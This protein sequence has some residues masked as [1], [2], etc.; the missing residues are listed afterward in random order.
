MVDVMVGG[1]YYNSTN[2]C[3]TFGVCASDGNCGF[4]T[5]VVGGR[6]GS[7]AC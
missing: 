7:E 1:S 6:A 2:S 4:V 5:F 3:N